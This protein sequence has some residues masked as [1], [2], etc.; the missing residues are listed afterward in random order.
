MELSR[1]KEILELRYEVLRKRK[2]IMPS[3]WLVIG[4]L[5]G[6]LLNLLANIIHDMFKSLNYGA[7]VGIVFGL[8]VITLLVFV[9]FLNKYY[10][11]PI[12][13][14]KEEIRKLEES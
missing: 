8:T 14:D 9:W 6:L 12:E 5:W 10:F 1:K 11:E 3:I 4:L 13:K 7:Y 2:E